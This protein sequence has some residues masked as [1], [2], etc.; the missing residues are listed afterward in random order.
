MEWELRLEGGCEGRKRGRGGG[1][2]FLFASVS[3]GTRR[4][5]PHSVATRR[6]PC[7]DSGRG[8]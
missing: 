6:L 4:H 3:C 8:S 7:S 2:G 1:A 5:T